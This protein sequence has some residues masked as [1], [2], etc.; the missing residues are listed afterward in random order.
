LQKPWGCIY[1]AQ[2]ERCCKYEKDRSEKANF[3]ATKKSR[4]KPNPTKNSF[5]QMSKKL[6]KLEK[7]I[8]NNVPNQRNVVEMIEIPTQNRELGWVA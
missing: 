5:A 3:C 6:E 7:A 1:Y 4:K 2:H 8:K